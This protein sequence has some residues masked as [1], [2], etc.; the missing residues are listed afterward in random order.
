M[1][2]TDYFHENPASSVPF[3]LCI[4]GKWILVD[5]QLLRAHPGG[6]A[7]LAYR[8]LDATAVFHAFHADSKLAY[9]WLRELR[10]KQTTVD[11]LEGNGVLHDLTNGEQ[12]DENEEKTDLHEKE[13]KRRLLNVN[14]GKFE[15]NPQES[16]KVCQSF[17]RL[18]IQVREKGLFKGDNSYFARKFIEAIGLI[19]FSLFLQSKEYFVLSAL[20]MGL[21]WQQLGWMIHEYGHQQHFKVFFALFYFLFF[22]KNRWW[23]DCCGYVCGNFLQG[24]SLAGMDQILTKRNKEK[25]PHNGFLYV[26]EKPSKDETKLFW[27]CEFQ[28]SKGINCKGRIHTDLE[29]NVLIAKGNHTCVENGPARVQSQL[30]VSNMKRRALETMEQPSTIRAAALQ[31]I[32]TPVM[33][34]LPSKDAIKKMIKLVR[35]E[36]GEKV[37]PP[38]AKKYRDADRRLLNLVQNYVPLIPDQNGQINFHADTFITYLAGISRNYLM[39]Q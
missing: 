9:T 37:S 31:N 8:N 20:F 25:I 30:A 16:E 7:M 24:F 4:D 18:K 14:M 23:N 32:P 11:S 12:K 15:L 33:A 27:R 5:E 22:L 13:I 6:G 34:Q 3:R 17:S 26:F 29:H 19:S 35:R 2:L 36:E 39:N 1:V 38:K 10:A 28:S 21:A